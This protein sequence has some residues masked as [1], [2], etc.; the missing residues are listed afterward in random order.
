[1]D[2]AIGSATDV[3]V[4]TSTYPRHPHDVPGRFLSTLL[5]ALPL[6]CKVVCPD[7]AAFGASPLPSVPRVPFHNAGLFYG[8]G[9]PANLHRGTVP[10]LARARSLS[11]LARTALGEAR[12]A[13]VVFSHWAVP[14]GVAGAL[15]RAILGR[16]HVL[17]LH[18]ADVHWLEEQRHGA[19]IARFVAR[20]TDRLFGV[21]D[22]LVRRFERLSGRRGLVLGCGVEDPLAVD[23]GPPRAPDTP[24]RVGTLG[25]LAPHKGVLPLLS[26]AAHLH[27]DLLVAGDG[28]E[29]AEVEARCRA[30]PGARYVGPLLGASKARYLRDLDVFVAPYARTA[31][32]QSEGL[33]TTILEAMAAARPVVAYRGAAPDDLLRDGETARLVPRGDVDALVRATNALLDD[34][35]GRAR[36]GAAARAAVRPH[37][38]AAVAPRWTDVLGELMSAGSASRRPAWCAHSRGDHSRAAPS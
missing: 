33:P 8:D 13:R 20:H 24:L 28:A 12:R 35:S 18:S 21:S 30:T 32:G 23:P 37:L 22:D 31:W 5:A 26:R 34:P 3:L 17:L 15:C 36:L 2:A 7:D 27:A 29:R 9:A 16:P 6:R 38:L 1:M 25:R 14:G 19:R 11:S 4:I 10:F